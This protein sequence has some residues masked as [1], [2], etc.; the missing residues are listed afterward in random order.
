MSI[1]GFLRGR[2]LRW[3]A[4]LEH[5][6]I[7]Q[8]PFERDQL[9]A[10]VDDWTRSLREPTAFYLDC[11]RCFHHLL[12]KQLQEHRAYFTAN[13]RG[14]GEDAFHTMWWL[15]FNRFA[16]R[17][18][19][20]IGVYRGQSL[21][22]ASLLQSLTQQRGG[23]VGISPFTSAGDSVSSYLQKIDYHADTL[24]NFR[25]FALPEPTLVRAFST[26]GVAIDVIRGRQWDCIYIDGNHD[27]EIAKADWI[28]CSQQV[29][30]GGLVVLDDSAL[31]TDYVPPRF[32]TAGH[33]GP[34]RVA[35]EI[36]PEEFR[37]ILRVGHNRVFQRL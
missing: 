18:F 37:E 16:V 27:Y 9:K 32:A 24:E 15:I 25:H 30:Q 19:L 12:P 17:D 29:R 28:V 31:G 7:L 34:S 3:R 13:R 21:S 26:D 6:R 33:P 8:L 22:L 5:R 10:A 23:I 35:A 20:E 1:L 14:F 2:W 11:H 36:N 4:R